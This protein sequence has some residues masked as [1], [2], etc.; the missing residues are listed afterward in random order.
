MPVPVPAPGARPDGSLRPDRCPAGGTIPGDRA[1]TAGEGHD[2]HDPEQAPPRFDPFSDE[3]FDDPYDL[4]RR[5]RDE[6]PVSFN[7]EYGFWA[8]FRY[9]DVRAAHLDWQTFTSTHGR[10]P[11]HAGRATPSWCG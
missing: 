4:Y 8:L 2:R 11:L 5:M 7:E 9:E 1:D 6:A 3:Y 10:R